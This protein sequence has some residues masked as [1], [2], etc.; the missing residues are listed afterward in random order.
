MACEIAPGALGI[1]SPRDAL[2]FATVCAGY[3]LLADIDHPNSTATK[4][5]GL[6]SMLASYLIRPA[7]GFVFELTRTSLDRG[8]GTHRG[9][10]HT[11]IFAVL[12]GVATNTSLHRWGTTAAW[13][14]AF[15]GMALAVKGI[16]HL[17]PGPPSMLIA[18][19]LTWVVVGA[20]P[21]QVG[22]SHTPWLGTAVTLGMLTHDLGD[23]ATEH[24]CCLL[25]PLKINGQRWYPIG[26]PR[27]MRFTTGRRA[28]TAI[29]LMLTGL[30]IWC[31]AAL[32]FP[33]NT[34]ARNTLSWVL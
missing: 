33:V 17:I 14:V 10:T 22:A 23:A 24:G 5:F 11:G 1:T 29:L 20:L 21:L 8:K 32:F 26:L 19:G 28:E 34:W 27:W 7:S 12:L 25:W 30:T 31:T 15:I 2:A 4:R 6:I 16:D 9:L 18:L 3:A 13:I